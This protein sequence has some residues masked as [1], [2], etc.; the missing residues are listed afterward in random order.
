MKK[1]S[2]PRKYY[3]EQ[4][5][6]L[7]RMRFTLIEL[8]VVIA[9]IAILA[10]ILLPALNSARERGRAASCINNMK[11]CV[12]AFQMYADSCGA[13]SVPFTFSAYTGFHMALARPDY[14]NIQNNAG[15]YGVNM[16]K[17]L[18][19]ASIECPSANATPT[20]HGNNAYNR[21]TIYATPYDKNYALG[22]SSSETDLC[23]ENSKGVVIHLSKLAK[24]TE[25]LIITDA[26]RIS[27]PNVAYSEY[28]AGTD[29]ALSFRH[30]GSLPMGFVD[31]HAEL[32]Q[33][34]DMKNYLQNIDDDRS[35]NKAKWN[36]G[37]S[38]IVG[39]K[40]ESW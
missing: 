8:L 30:G 34:A 35:P 37:A 11:Q 20:S 13:S 19:P 40:V 21:W 24:P 17:L 3:S 28:N 36:S 33:F 31:G 5:T 39:N 29:G 27:A 10:A 4:C 2:V 23:S 15:H 12:T 22:M 25:A 9:I 6:V 1:F 38:V 7:N 26:S 14:S 32:K 16:P 18:D